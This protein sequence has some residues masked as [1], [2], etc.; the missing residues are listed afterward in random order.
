MTSRD[1]TAL[2]L[3]YREEAKTLHGAPHS[4]LDDEKNDIDDG[5]VSHFTEG[6][7]ASRRNTSRRRRARMQP[8]WF[9]TH[10]DLR[11]DVFE[12]EKLLAEL[13]GMYAKHLLPSFG[14]IDTS[15]LEHDIRLRSLRLTEMLRSAERKVQNITK[16]PKPKV[17]GRDVE[18]ELLINMQR[19]FALPLQEISLSFRRKQKSYLE[20]LKEMKESL[21]GQPEPPQDTVITFQEPDLDSFDPN[22]SETQLLAVENASALTQERTRALQQVATNVNDLATLVKDLASLVVDQGTVLD[23]IDYNLEEAKVDTFSAVRELRITDR[24]QR[25]RHALCCIIVLSIACGVMFMILVY[26]WTT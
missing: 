17:S 11:G 20:K 19:R 25:K 18:N 24:K 16:R 3:R 15:E 12:M 9:F 14:D 26:K 6:D 4:F 22:T 8:D 10:T 2:F 21:D 13:S 5:L 1:R 7:G 23:R